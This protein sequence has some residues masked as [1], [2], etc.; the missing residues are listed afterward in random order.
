M[1]FAWFQIRFWKYLIDY[2]VMNVVM[3]VNQVKIY[4]IVPILFAGFNS[5]KNHKIYKKCHSDSR[6]SCSS[7]CHNFV[8]MPGL[9]SDENTDGRFTNISD[10]TSDWLGAI[11]N[12][13]GTL[14]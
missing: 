14:M 6:I 8:W 1:A 10:V 2:S 7:D 13:F 3:T 12:L 5:H 11:K 4:S 9:E